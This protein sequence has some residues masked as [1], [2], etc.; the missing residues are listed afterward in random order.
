MMLAVDGT[1]PAELRDMM[2][3]NWTSAPART[4]DSPAFEA[5]GGTRLRVGII[6][7]VLGL[8]QVMQHLEHIEEVARGNRGRV[9][10]DIYGV[11]LRQSFFSPAAGK[12]KIRLHHEQLAHEMT[13][14]G[15]RI[16]SGGEIAHAGNEAVGLYRR[17]PGGGGA[18]EEA[19]R[20]PH[21]PEK[22]TSGHVNHERWLIS[23]ADFIHC[24][25]RFLC[26]LFFFAGGSS[27]VGKL[28]TGHSGCVQELGV[29]PAAGTAVPLQAEGSVPPNTV[30]DAGEHSA[31]G[32]HRT[33]RFLA[34]GALGGER[35]EWRDRR[36]A[37]GA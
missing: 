32:Q 4:K 11:G 33:D 7:A 21:E 20:P 2:M 15:L 30:T 8:I 1:E 22:E 5:A 34:A 14:D 19:R 37:E 24:C 36:T 10:G 9:C 31:H 27:Q 26:P 28:A 29:F 12:L 25:S 6:G 17:C 16:H 18:E 13:L 23:Y 35:G 3:S